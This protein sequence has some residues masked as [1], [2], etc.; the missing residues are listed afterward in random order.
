MSVMNHSAQYFCSYIPHALLEQKGTVLLYYH[1]QFDSDA[2][3]ILGEELRQKTRAHGYVSWKL[4]AIFIELAQNIHFH[5]AERNVSQ[6]KYGALGTIILEETP[7]AFYITTINLVL[8]EQVERIAQRCEA[9]NQLSPAELRKYKNDLL[10][11]SLDEQLRGGN[12]GLVQVVLLSQEPV[13]CYIEPL[14]DAVSILTLSATIK[15]KD[16]PTNI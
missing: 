5:A 10:T 6:H 11:D 1:G 3:T 12:I 14:N 16:N 8:I 15:K 7:Q 9:V 4:F 2:I 13:S